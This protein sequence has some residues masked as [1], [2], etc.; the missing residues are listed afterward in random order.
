MNMHGF[1]ARLCANSLDELNR[2]RVAAAPPRT[3]ATLPRCQPR[4][5]FRRPNARARTLSFP[6]QLKLSVGPAIE[7]LV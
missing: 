6:L 2:E 7:V 3:P 5:I 1:T 4:R